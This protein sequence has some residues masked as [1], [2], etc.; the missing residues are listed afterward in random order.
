MSR[1]ANRKPVRHENVILSR[2]GFRIIAEGVGFQVKQG[3]RVLAETEMLTEAETI[4]D[5]EATKLLA[6]TQD[7]AHK[8]EQAAERAMEAA[9]EFRHANGRHCSGFDSD[10]L[11]I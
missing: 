11:P 5:R 1:F 2:E 6:E 9:A 4:M 7:R 10:G 8:A 3:A